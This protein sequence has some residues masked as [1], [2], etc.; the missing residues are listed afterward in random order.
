M[1]NNLINIGEDGKYHYLYKITN[2][3]NQRYYYGIHST[4][5]LNSDH[6]M[7][8]GKVLKKAI[9]KYGVENFKKDIIKFV[10]SRK[11]LIQLEKEIVNEKMLKDPLCYNMVLGGSNFL[12]KTV[13]KITVIDKTGN[14]FMVDVNDPRRLSGELNPIAYGNCAAKDKFGNVF[15]VK[16][17]DIRFFTG[18]LTGISKGMVVAYDSNNISY[19][20]KTDDDRLKSGELVVRCNNLNGR[21]DWRWVKKG[22]DCKSIHKTELEYYLSNGWVV[23]NIH[24]GL[25]CITKDGKNKRVQQ[26]D[27]QTYL[28]EGWQ[29]GTNQRYPT[30]SSSKGMRYVNKDG[31]CK[32]ISP[33]AL[34]SYLSNG[35]KTGKK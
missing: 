11:E 27:L 34:N 32:L 28:D 23:G 7:G 12:N 3:I 29:L 26:K 14:T 10:N 6:Y 22:N 4:K 21:K 9:C 25:K 2:K 1:D 13:G 20:V 8:S 30:A 19:W 5:N 16:K 15:W 35:W 31:V 18:E 17:D 33:E 24:K